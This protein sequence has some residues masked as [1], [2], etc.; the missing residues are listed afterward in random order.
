M[1]QNWN[2]NC[3]LKTGPVSLWFSDPEPL[4]VGCGRV[5]NYT[6]I[7]HI[8]S[9]LLFLLCCAINGTPVFYLGM[10]M[11]IGIGIGSIEKALGK[12]YRKGTEFEICIRWV[13]TNVVT[14]YFLLIFLSW[15]H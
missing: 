8:L 12:Y 13:V 2:Q 5:V 1:S 15:D 9:E 6:V 14:F 3:Y 10:G 7:V 11:G 4:I